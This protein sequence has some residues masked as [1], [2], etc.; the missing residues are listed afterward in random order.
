[1]NMRIEIEQ[2][3]ARK[4]LTSI[5]SVVYHTHDRYEIV[6]E[7]ERAYLLRLYTPEQ[8]H[9][10][11]WF[12]KSVVTFGGAEPERKPHREFKKEVNDV[13][14]AEGL[15]RMTSFLESWGVPLNGIQTKD[16]AERVIND[17][18]LTEKWNDEK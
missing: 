8:Q 10:S 9:F 11:K 16:D 1:M 5:E 17:Y 13:W 2:W 7:T 18:G 4:N 6:S 3:F 14:G 12:P 15:K